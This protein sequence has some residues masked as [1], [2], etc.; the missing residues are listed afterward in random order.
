MKSLSDVRLVVQLAQLIN[1]VIHIQIAGITMIMVH[2]TTS[3]REVYNK[4][5]SNSLPI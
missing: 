5:N 3:K 1:Y 4:K 2:D